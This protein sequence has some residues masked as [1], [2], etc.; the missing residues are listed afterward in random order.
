MVR[1]TD[2][3]EKFSPLIVK[4]VSVTIAFDYESF[5]DINESGDNVKT[6]V[7]TWSVH[8]FTRK[9]SFEQIQNFIL[10]EIN[11]RIDEKIISGFE[12][13]G[14]PVWLS[15]ENQF[16]YKAAYDLA[17]QTN[18]VS[19]PVT[20]KFGDAFTPVYYK[21]D[22]VEDLTDFFTSAMS[23]INTCLMDGWYRKDSIDWE[24]YKI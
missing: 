16:N 7:G 5:Y 12:W 22:N 10:S 6:D 21:F 24:Q 13:K 3:N 14:M 20:F 15:S 2:K 9:P 8:T 23:Y 1:I 18:G 17:V 19:L 11:K 4:G